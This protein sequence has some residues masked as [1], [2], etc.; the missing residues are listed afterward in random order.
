MFDTSITANVEKEVGSRKGEW[1]VVSGRAEPHK[2]VLAVTRNIS[3][4]DA[5][6]IR[7]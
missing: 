1:I 7:R 4:K 2:G 6:K 3:R 5:K